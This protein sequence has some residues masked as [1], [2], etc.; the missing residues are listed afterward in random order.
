MRI[1]LVRL[2]LLLLAIFSLSLVARN[3]LVQTAN[4]NGQTIPFALSPDDSVQLLLRNRLLQVDLLKAKISPRRV[5]AVAGDA[6]RIDPLDFRPFLVAGLAARKADQSQR[7]AALLTAARQRQPRNFNIRRLLMEV[8]LMDGRYDDAAREILASTRLRSTDAKPLMQALALFGGDSSARHALLQILSKRADWR[9]RFTTNPDV[10]ALA[11]DLVMEVATSRTTPIRDRLV[12]ARALV[13]GQQMERGY[14]L[15]AQSFSNPAMR[16]GEFP[17]DPGFEGW[18]QS[19]G[20]GWKFP[21][22]GDGVAEIVKDEGGKGHVLDVEFFGGAAI[23]LVEQPMLLKPGRYQLS[24]AGHHIDGQ[25][26]AGDYR[27]TINCEDNVEPIVVLRIAS[28][29]SSKFF[30]NGEFIVPAEDC[31]VQTLKMMIV[32]G[33]MSI[34]MRSIF[35]NVGIMRQ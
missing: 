1:W 14:A 30:Q 10:V 22:T 27:W 12:I 18:A 7:S 5:A 2:V 15:W 21:E 23:S 35:S 28:S 9:A 4:A 16:K 24:I 17:T 29:E 32:P 33:E 3:A 25:Q 20:F 19:S 26:G 13:D 8:Y 6:T 11:P 31:A 34:S